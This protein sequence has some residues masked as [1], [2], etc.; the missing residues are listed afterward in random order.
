MLPKKNRADRKIIEKIFKE[1]NF[2]NSPNI[3]LRFILNNTS[4][5]PRISFIAPRSIAKLA[6]KRN[7]LR[8]KGYAILKKYISQFPSGLIGAFVFKKYQEDILIIE[9]EIKN[10]LN[11]IN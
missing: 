8:R 5:I 7:L 1:G 2:L 11:K 9:D 3:T 4:D 6:V 10:I